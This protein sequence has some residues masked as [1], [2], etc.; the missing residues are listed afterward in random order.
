MY[1]SLC[2]HFCMSVLMS[3]RQ[4]LYMVDEAPVCVLCATH[5]N[6]AQKLL[7]TVIHAS[8]PF[9]WHHL[10]PCTKHRE[11]EVVHYSSPYRISPQELSAMAFRFLWRNIRCWKLL[12]VSGIAAWMLC[13]S[14]CFHAALLMGFI[15]SRFLILDLCIRNFITSVLRCDTH[16]QVFWSYLNSSQILEIAVGGTRHE[17]TCTV[18]VYK[19]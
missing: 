10:R 11:Q 8:T 18:Q 14:M 19:Y 13:G 7:S 9:A 16:P 1:L 4:Y 6:A 17:D 5:K 3:L 2:L 12:I 15:T